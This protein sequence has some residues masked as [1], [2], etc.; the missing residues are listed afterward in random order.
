MS[1]W[2]WKG[3]A[4]G[5]GLMVSTV[6]TLMAGALLPAPWGLA[7]FA[8]GL[9]AGGLCLSGRGESLVLRVVLRA[10]PLHAAERDSMRAALTL[11]SQSYLGP[12]LVHVWVSPSD[13]RTVAE[14]VGQRTVVVAGGVL[15]A[16]DESRLTQTQVAAMIGRPAGLVRDGWAG[17]DVAI[18]V[19]SFPWLLLRAIILGVAGPFLRLPVVALT[20]RLRVVVIVIAVVQAVEQGLPWLACLTGLFGAV[21]YAT[22]LTHR[23]WRAMLQLAGDHA[24]REAGL[25]DPPAR[26]RSGAR[27]RVLRRGHRALQPSGRYATP[28][29]PLQPQ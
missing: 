9:V 5:P 15:D 25:A 27:T 12:P 23:R 1:R 7:P 14:A 21:S 6:L 18:T 3:L 22:P 24:V 29:R 16:L 10:R 19:W 28:V 2:I 26:P 8:V 4:V 13:R 17:H 11:L 20:W